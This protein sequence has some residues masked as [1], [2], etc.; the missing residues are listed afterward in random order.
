MKKGFLQEM[1]VKVDTTKC[2]G[3]GQCVMAASEVFDQDEET[4]IVI[5]K[6]IEPDGEQEADVRTAA[7]RCPVRAIEIV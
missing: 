7:R 2:I 3:A 4:G 5:L 1:R 6:V